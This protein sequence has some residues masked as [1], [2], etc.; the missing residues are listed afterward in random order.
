MRNRIR[1]YS[2]AIV[3]AIALLL[4]GQASAQAGTWNTTK[5]MDTPNGGSHPASGVNCESRGRIPPPAASAGFDHLVFCDDFDSISTIDVKGTGA[6]GFSWYTKLPFGGAQTLPSAYSVS[7][8]VLTVTS[9]GYTGNWAL[10]TRDPV[11][12]NGHAWNFGFFEARVKFDPTLGPES[13]GW[14][15]FWSLSAYHTQYNN[16]DIWP[17]LDF[18]EAYTGGEASYSGAFVGTLHQWQDS[19]SINYQNSNNFQSTSVDWN[20]WHVLGC[21]WVP[22]Q[23][24]WYLDGN[25]LMT[26]QY[27]ATAPPNPLANTA[28]GITPTPAGVFD[29]IDTQTMQLIVGSSPGWPLN[30]DYVRVWQ[31]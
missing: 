2:L 16:L 7:H 23:I 20:E 25:P 18:F 29:V 31:N 24:T 11:T 6:P 14:P 4:S 3:G 21:L 15:S 28:G 19:G 26:Q 5:N 17:E 8:S 1:L 22:G 13:Q 10:T 30:I 27:S 12:G 9:T